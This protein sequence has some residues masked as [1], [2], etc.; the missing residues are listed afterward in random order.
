MDLALV[1]GY[2]EAD[3]HRDRRAEAGGTH[4]TCPNCG[5]GEW[6]HVVGVPPEDGSKRKYRACKVCGFRQEADG[7]PGYRSLM[8]VHTCLGFLPPGHRCEYCGTCGPRHWHAGCWRVLAPAELGQSTCHVCNVVL[9]REH[10][11]PWPVAAT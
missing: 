2:T 9:S 8:T 10:V 7:T 5:R 3:W 6:F 1:P 11:I 4:L